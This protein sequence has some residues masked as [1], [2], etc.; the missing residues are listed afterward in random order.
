VDEAIGLV[1]AGR[2][3]HGVLR[4]GGDLLASRDAIAR[5]EA[6]VI[7][8]A[9]ED[10]GAIVAEELGDPRVAL[11]GVKTLDSVRDAIARALAER[12]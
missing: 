2:D 11:D 1:A 5:V 4:V 3:R 12:G 8:A 9:P 6:R 7:G 10:I